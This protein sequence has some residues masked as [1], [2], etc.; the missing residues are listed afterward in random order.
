MSERVTLLIGDCRETLR[1]L[2]D[3][4]AVPRPGSCSLA[5]RSRRLKR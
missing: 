1:T 4:S 2:P 3:A 5:R